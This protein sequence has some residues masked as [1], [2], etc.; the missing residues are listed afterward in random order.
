MKT[1][2]IIDT[3]EGD[4]DFFVEKFIEAGISPKV[5]KLDTGDFLLY[6]KD[7]DEAYLIE[8]KTASDLLGSIE[9]NKNEDG[10]WAEGRIWDQLTRMKKSGIKNLYVIV[11]GNPFSSR[12]TAYRKKGFS[13]AR[14]WG[15]YT[16]IAKF[17]V[18]IFNTKD[19][20][21]TAE[22]LIFIAKKL[23]RPK[24]EFALRT[25]AP[26]SM[27]LIEKRLYLLQSLPS[28]GPV[29]SKRILKMFKTPSEFFRNL[30]KID[31]I[32]GIGEKTK[33]EILK[34]YG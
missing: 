23:G 13:K 2:V 1:D 31:S 22:W 3:R 28:I 17:G 25:S 9:G 5:E 30:D 12:L 7:K 10:T 16:G 32:E 19:K 18:Q 29:A 6:G 15:A 33:K 8:R 11:E 21:E 24:K 26:H 34:I 27:T 14:I 20:D 4:I